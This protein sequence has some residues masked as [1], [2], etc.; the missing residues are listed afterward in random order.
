VK[1]HEASSRK[2]GKQEGKG[3]LV[4]LVVDLPLNQLV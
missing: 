1:T 3:G 4:V 2:E